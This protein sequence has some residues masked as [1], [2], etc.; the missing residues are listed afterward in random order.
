M[1]HIFVTV[2][3]F[4][5]YCF[6][7]I[8]QTYTQVTNV[9][10]PNNTTVQDVYSLTS[11]DI[12][13]TPSQLAVLASDLAS[14]YNGA[15]LIDIPSYK[16]NCHAYAWHISEGGNKVWIG[17]YTSTAEDIY[18]ADGSYFEVPENIATKVSYHQD[19]NHSAI[20]L[21]STWYQSKWGSSALVKHHPNDVPLIYQP[22]LLKKYYSI[23]PS[24]SGPS[25]V[26]SSGGTFTINNLLPVDSIIWS[27]GSCLSVSSGQ[28]TANCTFTATDDGNSWV[29]ARL[30]NGC[31]SVT[32]PQQT[33][34]AGNIPLQNNEDVYVYDNNNGFSL[35]SGPG[36]S[37]DPY[38]IC[39]GNYYTIVIQL[40][41]VQEIYSV[42]V[43]ENWL[44]YQTGV[45]EYTFQPDNMTEGS[46][47][48]SI[49]Y[50]GTC[51]SSVHIL[52]FGKNNNC[53]P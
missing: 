3:C 42:T 25:V 8:A 10:T 26:C 24:I 46:Y 44:L 47:T 32:L 29:R 19:G 40:T 4:M 33:V 43:P 20:K 41:N 6:T 27:C 53:N 7:G 49:D 14:N 21:N 52:Y 11:S 50:L 5:V 17:R 38:L 48:V 2:F 45:Y 35:V 39:P 9:K 31:G 1:K 28:N 16:Y 22:L 12:S 37:T 34:W 15:E 30:V 36:T 23:T 51:S 13:L 18:W